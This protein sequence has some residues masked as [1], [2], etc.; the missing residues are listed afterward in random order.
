MTYAEFLQLPPPFT[1]IL[2]FIF[3][4]ILCVSGLC[5]KSFIGADDELSGNEELWACLWCF[6][7]AEWERN[8]MVA[9]SKLIEDCINVVG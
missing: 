4:F 2:D 6:K 1:Y 5:K 7:V 9:N 8:L 3:C